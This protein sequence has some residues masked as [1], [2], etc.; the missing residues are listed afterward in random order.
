[1]RI[2]SATTLLKTWFT[3]IWYLY[4]F[5]PFGG[6]GCGRNSQIYPMSRVPLSHPSSSRTSLRP[7]SAPSSPAR[8]RTT[9]TGTPLKVRAQSAAR[10]KTPT[11]NASTATPQEPAATNTSLSI[12]EAI[13][14]R[15]AEAKKS[16]EKGNNSGGH[17]FISLDDPSPT[18]T[19][20]PQDEDILGRWPVRETIE[21]ARSTG[22]CHFTFDVLG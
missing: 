14:R 2:I 16:Q 22:D 7:P 21:R 15:R 9:S 18:T 1:V 3:V 11:K 8:T 10:S 13:A 5:A 20:K 6:C 12:K 19:S 4:I 17:D